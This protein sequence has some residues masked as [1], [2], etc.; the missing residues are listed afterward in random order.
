MRHQENESPASL[1]VLSLK[2]GLLLALASLK[3]VGDLQALF[4]NTVCLEFGPNDSKFV[5]K[6]RLGSVPKVISTPFRAQIITFSTFPPPTDSQESLLCPVRALRI[7]IERSASYIKS[8]QL[9]VGFSNCVKGG[10]VTKQRISR[11]L[12]DAITLAYSSSGLQCPI[13]VRAH[14]TRHGPAWCPLG[15]SEYSIICI[16]ICIC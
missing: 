10:L 16:C 2:T 12:V 9:F 13:G 5:L 6:T 1:R 11:W 15:M 8:E 14:S 7:Y 4:V 3:R